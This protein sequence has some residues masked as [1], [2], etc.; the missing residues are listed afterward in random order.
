MDAKEKNLLELQLYNQF[1]NDKVI[2][3]TDL[4]KTMANTFGRSRD[5]VYEGMNSLIDA[6]KIVLPKEETYC[7]PGV[8]ERKQRSEATEKALNQTT[9]TR[10]EL[11]KLHP[12]EKTKFFKKG[13]RVV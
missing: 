1:Q 7:Y 10:A 9:I 8:W 6:G 12:F 13:G 11:D 2:A 5:E 3:W 4:L